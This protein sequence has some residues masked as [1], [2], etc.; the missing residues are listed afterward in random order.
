[1]AQGGLI[2]TISPSQLTVRASV[3]LEEVL[4]VS[5]YGNQASRATSPVEAA[6]RHGPYL[7]EHLRILADGR[8]LQGRLIQST[9]SGT[10]EKAQRFVYDFAYSLKKPASELRFE[11]DVLNEFEFAPGNRWEASYIVEI[12][13]EGQV[14]RE[15]LLLTSRQPLVFLPENPAARSK[16]PLRLDRWQ[17]VRDYFRHGLLH[18]LTGYDHLLFVTAL[19]LT[20]RTL[21]ELVKVITA[22]TLAHSITLA[23]SAFDVFRLPSTIVEPAIAASIIFVAL[24]NVFWPEQ[25]R[26]WTRLAV[27]FFFGLFHG[28]GFAGGLLQ[29]MQGMSSHALVLAVLGFSAGVEV[30]HQIVVLPTFC[31][32]KLAHDRWPSD[33]EAGARSSLISR[34]L[35]GAISL[36]GM[37]YLGAALRWW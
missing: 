28:L 35:S 20:V 26:G 21:W 30:G 16:T 13:E 2:V 24:Q 3:S 29:A 34:G 37:V 27:A 25:T 18:I 22:F 32:L 14:A 7:L 31:A 4:V 15:G 11:E 9:N 12:V 33:T 1:V 5:A 8:P 10:D 6:A 17:V 19:V 23:L 36:A